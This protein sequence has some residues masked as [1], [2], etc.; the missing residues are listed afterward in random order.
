MDEAPNKR[1]DLVRYIK[2]PER[3]QF[4]TLSTSHSSLV[5]LLQRV[6]PSK[7]T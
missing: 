6:Q 4:S 3:I 7:F 5:K 1:Q 2:P